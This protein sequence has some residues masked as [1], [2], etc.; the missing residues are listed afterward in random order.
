MLLQIIPMGAQMSPRRT[1]ARV[2]ALFLLSALSCNR[3]PAPVTRNRE[4]PAGL[5]P[6][7]SPSQPTG[8]AASESGTLSHS[9]GV[10]EATTPCGAGETMT[11]AGCR[12]LA[13]IPAGTPTLGLVDGETGAPTCS[14]AAF[15]VDVLEVTVQQFEVCVLAGHCDDPVEDSFCNYRIEGRGEH[16][17]NCVDWFSA[18]QYCEWAGGR[19]PT[20]YEWE[21]SARGLEGM[22]P[23]PWGSSEPSGLRAR[24][25]G[26]CRGDGDCGTSAGGARIA[27][28]SSF[29]VQDLCGNVAEWTSS[30]R[31]DDYE[32]GSGGSCPEPTSEVTGASVY[33]YR[34][35]GWDS[36][37]S[38]SWVHYRG[39]APADYASESLGFRCRFP[40]Q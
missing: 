4:P 24:I 28:A 15:M 13:R 31:T 32:V 35:G 14:L 38:E 10:L 21:Y 26:T 3:E 27:G 18:T 6:A 8:L 23:Y 29:G 30:P 36:Q 9:L 25:T 19:L 22:Q 33:S 12:Q 20:E 7:P 16:P 37:L 34:G 39:G 17:M 1:S 5:S 2:V 40:V 11:A